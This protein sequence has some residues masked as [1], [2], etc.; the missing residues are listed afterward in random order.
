MLAKD[1]GDVVIPRDVVQELAAQPPDL[2]LEAEP[3]PPVRE[4]GEDKAPPPV[5]PVLGTL[6][7][8]TVIHKSFSDEDLTLIYKALFLQS[9]DINN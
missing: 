1:L 4:A 2:V 8:L 9:I 7:E 3:L 5:P 6:V